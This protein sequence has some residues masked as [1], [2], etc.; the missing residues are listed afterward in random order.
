L[1]GEYVP[2]VSAVVLALVVWTGWSLNAGRKAA[3]WGRRKLRWALFVTAML[4]AA[5]FVIRA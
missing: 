5:V 4:I 2:I 1:S 3:R